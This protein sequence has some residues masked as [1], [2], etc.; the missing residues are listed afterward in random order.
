MALEAGIIAAEIDASENRQLEQAFTSIGITP[1]TF[2]IDGVGTLVGLHGAFSHAEVDI[3]IIPGFVVR[4]VG[5]TTLNKAFYRFD[6]LYALESRGKMLIN[7]AFALEN[8]MDKMRTSVIL[9][10]RGLPTPRT[11]VAENVKQALAAFDLLGGDIVVKPV[12]GSQ[13]IGIF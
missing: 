2:S 5:L 12:Y 3:D 6:V 8:A 10:A 1:R 4:G 11:E 9:D 7:N 13:G